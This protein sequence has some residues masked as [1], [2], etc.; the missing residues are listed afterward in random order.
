MNAKYLELRLCETNVH[1]ITISA[2]FGLVV[3]ALAVVFNHIRHIHD[4]LTIHGC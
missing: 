3:F 1:D 4:Y 2:V